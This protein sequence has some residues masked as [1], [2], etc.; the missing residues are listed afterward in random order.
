MPRKRLWAM[1]AAYYA[2][3]AR[4]FRDELL[5]NNVNPYADPGLAE[6]RKSGYPDTKVDKLLR[7]EIVICNGPNGAALF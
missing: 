7:H 6:T 2:A 5:T 3:L 1:L 4:A